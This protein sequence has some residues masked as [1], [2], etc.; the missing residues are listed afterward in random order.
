[1]PESL[2]GG[3]NLGF[4]FLPNY[5]AWVIVASLAICI[6]TWFLI[7]KHQAGRVPARRDREPEDGARPSA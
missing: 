2:T 5:R 6:G 3:Q 7:E 1:M 4:M